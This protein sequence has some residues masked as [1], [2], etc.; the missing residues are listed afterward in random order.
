MWITPVAGRM[1]ETQQEVCTCCFCKAE[2]HLCCTFPETSLHI[3]RPR[4]QSLHKN[5]GLQVDGASLVINQVRLRC[6][7]FGERLA[8]LPGLHTPEPSPS[9]LSDGTA[10]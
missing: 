3:A 1:L 10:G 7:T 5:W 2:S 8:I 9:R 4:L 6:T